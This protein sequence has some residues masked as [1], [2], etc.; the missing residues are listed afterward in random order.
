MPV[1]KPTALLGL[2]GA[3]KAFREFDM[4]FPIQQ[5]E[6]L[7]WVAQKPG[8]SVAELVKLTGQAQSSV[9]RNV[10]ALGLVHRKGE[11][12]HDFVDAQKDPDN[13][14][15]LI[16]FLTFKG[17]HFMTVLLKR[18]DPEVEF[19]AS[20]YREWTSKSFARMC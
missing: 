1:H 16:L 14:R 7:L 18:I 9:S 17:R 3:I 4:N 11:P 15:R 20:T 19:I 12:G 13:P 10:A 2:I 6:I 8:V 5:I